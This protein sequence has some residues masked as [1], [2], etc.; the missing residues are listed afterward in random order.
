MRRD[1]FEVDTRYVCRSVQS[2]NIDVFNTSSSC[3][4]GTSWAFSL[5]KEMQVATSDLIDWLIPFDIIEQ[6]AEYLSETVPSSLAQ[7]FICNCTLNGPGKE[8]EYSS[9]NFELLP[10]DVLV[11]QSSRSNHQMS[12]D[13]IVSFVDRIECNTT[14]HGLEWWQICDEITER[15]NAI[16]ES[17]CHLLEFQKC[18]SDE[19]QCRNGMC[20]PLEFAFD[21][22]PNCM[23]SSDEQELD[24]MYRA[25]YSCNKHSSALCDA[26]FCRENQF[27][28]GNGQCVSWTAIFGYSTGCS[29]FR[30]A[31]YSCE[32]FDDDAKRNPLLTGIC[33]QTTPSLSPLT[34]ESNCV[35]SLR[36]LLRASQGHLAHIQRNIS[37]HNILQRCPDLIEYP[38]KTGL[39]GTMK[40]FYNKSYIHMFYSD[41]KY[42]HRLI[43]RKPHLYYFNSS[44][45][46]HMNWLNQ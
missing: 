32:I 37:F 39:P 18:E 45:M 43:P 40:T 13:S 22:R 7:R 30:H 46:C 35:T 25:Y 26:R 23:D 31:A 33:Q 3:Y 14:F 28:C 12:Y 8:Y 4:D 9:S 1:C 11:Q 15:D 21:A 36:H 27:S 29:N 38:L 24:E 10:S 34:Q 5:L 16:D 2:N 41:E 44:I 42:L 19:F 17:D 20:I 6:Y